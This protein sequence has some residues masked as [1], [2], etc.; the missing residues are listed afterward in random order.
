[1]SVETS[2]VPLLQPQLDAITAGS[3]AFLSSHLNP[4]E[5]ALLRDQFNDYNNPYPVPEVGT[6]APNFSL[7]DHTGKTVQLKEVASTHHVILVWYR[8]EWCPFCQATL[9]TL[10]Q[11]LPAYTALNA[12]VF[13]I[14]P[15]LPSLTPTTVEKFALQFPILSDVGNTTAKAYGTLYQLN[16]DLSKIQTKLGVDWQKT[17]GDSTHQL[18]HAGFFIVER[19][20]GK[21]AYAHVNPNFRVRPE[22]SELVA[23]LKKLNEK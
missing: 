21:L 3:G 12:K 11:H 15:T 2:S 16:E 6:A 23:V 19:G 13:A 5:L 10:N 14:T 22:P 1:M 17:Y 8:G 18:P 9:K 20:T 7:V 4:Q